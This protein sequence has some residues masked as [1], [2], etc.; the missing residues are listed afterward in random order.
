MR[1]IIHKPHIKRIDYLDQRFYVHESKE[2][3]KYFPSVTEILSI[4]PKGFGFEQWLK[5][6][7][8]NASQIADRAASVG[9]KIHSHTELLNQGYELKWT[10]EG[11]NALFTI[12]EW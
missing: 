3:D 11:G 6:V 1:N 12:Q 5:D 2:G 8:S 9:S 7:G 4:Y 10:D